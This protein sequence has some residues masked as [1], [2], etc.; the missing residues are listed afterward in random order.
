MKIA[1]TAAGTDLQAPLDPRFGRAAKFILFDTD[2]RQ[3][4]VFD[5]A[6]NLNAPQGAGVQSAETVS[7]LGAECLLTGH[8]GPKAFRALAAAGIP[9]F[10]GLEGSVADAIRLYESGKLETAA[11]ADVDGHWQ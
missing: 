4:E 5:N 2:T 1:I 6:Q 7:R 8:C 11:S 10:T 3:F 9:V